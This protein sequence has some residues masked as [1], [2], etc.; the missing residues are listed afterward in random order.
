MNA[1]FRFSIPSIRIT[2]LK[3]FHFVSKEMEVRAINNEEAERDD[4]SLMRACSDRDN[5]VK[6]RTTKDFSVS[7]KPGSCE[8][9]VLFFF[10]LFFLSYLWSGRVRYNP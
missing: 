5:A 10:F 8:C 3:E 2:N 9:P 7:M 4:C 6:V 1:F